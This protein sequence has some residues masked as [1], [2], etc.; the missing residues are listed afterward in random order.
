MCV[1]SPE[2]DFNLHNNVNFKEKHIE[3]LF[4]SYLNFMFSGVEHEKCITFGSAP[5][6][7]HLKLDHS[8]CSI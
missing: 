3:L 1:H 4:M 6:M 7:F 8:D 2:P 5:T